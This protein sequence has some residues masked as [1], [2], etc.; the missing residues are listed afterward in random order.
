MNFWESGRDR[1]ASIRV[2]HQSCEF[3]VWVRVVECVE[4]IASSV[5]CGSCA[6]GGVSLSFVGGGRGMGSLHEDFGC[7]GVGLEWVEIW[8]G[9]FCWA[10]IDRWKCEKSN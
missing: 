7:H 1:S 2:A 4:G 6:F 9:V 3:P 8:C 10:E 5:S